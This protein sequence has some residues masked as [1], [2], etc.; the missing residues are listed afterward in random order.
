M[1]HWTSLKAPGDSCLS[2][3]NKNAL[4]PVIN[5]LQDTFKAFTSAGWGEAGVSVIDMSFV[6]RVRDAMAEAVEES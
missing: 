2:H 5:L 4:C 3:R 1:L 6:E